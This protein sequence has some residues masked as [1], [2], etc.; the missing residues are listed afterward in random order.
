MRRCVSGARSLHAVGRAAR[1]ISSQENNHAEDDQE[2]GDDQQ[3][4]VGPRK[5]AH[6][7]Q[8]DQNRG[9]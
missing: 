6:D 7:Q 8:A 5:D 9:G 3:T 1:S 4:R 2:A